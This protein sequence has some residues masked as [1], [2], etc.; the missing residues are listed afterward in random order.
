MKQWS[1]VWL[2][3]SCVQPM[4][5]NFGRTCFAC[6]ERR[7]ASYLR[8]H[9]HFTF[10]PCTLQMEKVTDVFTIHRCIESNPLQL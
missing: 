9:G 8:N 1:W 6:R 2:V 5:R 3:G 10:H 4:P 7:E